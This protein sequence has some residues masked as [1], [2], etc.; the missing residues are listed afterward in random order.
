VA[1]GR[2]LAGDHCFAGRTGQLYS[3][4]KGST[5]PLVVGALSKT[6]FH[7]KWNPAVLGSFFLIF[8]DMRGGTLF[9]MQ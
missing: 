1:I 3:G 9:V 5:R 6:N 2:D 7:K 8:F 4:I